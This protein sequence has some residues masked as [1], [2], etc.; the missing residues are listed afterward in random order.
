MMSQAVTPPPGLLIR[1]TIA[2]TPGSASRASSFSRNRATGF[3]PIEPKP[4]MLRLRRRPSTST[5]A[6]LPHPV[7]P[8]PIVTVAS[9]EARL[10]VR[11]EVVRSPDMPR[12][13]VMFI[14]PAMFMSPFMFMSPSMQTRIGCERQPAWRLARRRSS[15]TSRSPNR[16]RSGRRMTIP[17]VPRRPHDRLDRHSRPWNPRSRPIEAQL[18]F[19]PHLPQ[20]PSGHAPPPATLFPSP[21]PLP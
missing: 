1:S 18:A 15:G 5:M 20:P 17:P 16:N 8:R 13:P 21:A 3:S 9:R 10:S 2:A 4:P 11:I 14:A 12:S 6:T 19:L 7:A